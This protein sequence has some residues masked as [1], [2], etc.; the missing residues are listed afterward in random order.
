MPAVAEALAGSLRQGPGLS[1]GALAKAG[2][3]EG[4]RTPVLVTVRPDFY[5][6]SRLSVLGEIGPADRVNLSGHPVKSR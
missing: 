3:G 4:S 1:A 5:M 2:G 6:L